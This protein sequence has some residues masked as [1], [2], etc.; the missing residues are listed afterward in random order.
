MEGCAW[1]R[2]AEQA[3]NESADKEPTMPRMPVIK[4][5]MCSL[6]GI[7][8]RAIAPMM[9]PTMNIQIRC[10]KMVLP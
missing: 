9:M 7:K 4:I 6:P 10:S 2:F 1:R 8:K 3:G 5:L